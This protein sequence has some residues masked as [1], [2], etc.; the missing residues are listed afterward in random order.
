MERELGIVVVTGAATPT[1]SA[2]ADAVREAHGRLIVL[3]GDPPPDRV[4]FLAA[5]LTDAAAM[6]AAAVRLT[7]RLPYVAGLVTGDCFG[8]PLAV[9][10]R[11]VPALQDHLARGQGRLVVVAAPDRADGVRAAVAA[12]PGRTSLIVAEDPRDI[13]AEVVAELRVSPEVRARERVL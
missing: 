2:V 10:E 1:G 13:A 7:R 8:V 5:D 3:G 12:G 6:A 9:V 11:L 4:E